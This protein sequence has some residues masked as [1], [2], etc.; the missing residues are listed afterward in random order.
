LN[1]SRSRTGSGTGKGLA[2]F[3]VQQLVLAAFSHGQNFKRWMIVHLAGEKHRKL[4]TA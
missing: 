1:V 3:I 2:V 4:S